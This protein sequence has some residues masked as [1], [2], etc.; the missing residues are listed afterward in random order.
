M[1]Q[2][3]RQVSA[4]CI[5]NYIQPPTLC[6]AWFTNKGTTK[7]IWALVV[8]LTERERGEGGS[9]KLVW[10]T[11]HYKL[12]A[13]FKTGIAHKDSGGRAPQTRPLLRLLVWVRRGYKAMGGAR[14]VSHPLSKVITNKKHKLIQYYH[15]ILPTFKAACPLA[16]NREG[17]RKIGLRR[18]RKGE[19]GKRSWLFFQ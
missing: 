6:N 7:K 14:L 15:S 4:M 16:G 9:E 17:G 13:A 19:Q 1:V 11:L 2:L 10:Q 5:C 3:V 8:G 18:L 12:S